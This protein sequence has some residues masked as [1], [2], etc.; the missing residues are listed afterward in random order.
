[1][2]WSIIQLKKV[3]KYPHI[4]HQDTY[5]IRSWF[6][7]YGSYTAVVRLH[8][9]SGRVLYTEMVCKCLHSTI[10]SFSLG[11]LL[12]NSNLSLFSGFVRS[13][14]LASVNSRTHSSN[15]CVA[16]VP[17]YATFHFL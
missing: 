10:A 2:E 5:R 15:A 1:M 14:G 8:V 4:V 17:S 9:R 13:R 16:S 6:L 7:E 12:H 11:R 3:F